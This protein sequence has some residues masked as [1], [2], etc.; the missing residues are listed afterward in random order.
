LH[1]RSAELPD[2]GDAE[3]KEVL[4][5]LY[6]DEHLGCRRLARRNGNGSRSYKPQGFAEMIQ[7]LNSSGRVVDGRGERSDRDVDHDADREGRILID[8]SLDPERDHPAH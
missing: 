2:L 7:H 4:P 3:R 5:A 6:R 1:R 8:R